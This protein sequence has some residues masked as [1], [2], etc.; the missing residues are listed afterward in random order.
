VSAT[1]KERK[2]EYLRLR[3]VADEALR[4]D[5]AGL[6]KASADAVDARDT[7]EREYI[8]YL[9]DLLHDCHRSTL[10]FS[11]RGIRSAPYG[12]GGLQALAHYSSKPGDDSPP[13]LLGEFDYV[14]TVSGGGYLGGWLSAWRYW[15]ENGIR[16]VINTLGATPLDKLDP[17]PPALRHLRSYTAYLTPRTGFLSADTWTLIATYMRNI[18]LNWLVLMPIFGAV[19]MVPMVARAGA[20]LR[21]DFMPFAS[22]QATLALFL[23]G[24]FICIVIPTAY[25]ARVL[26]SF[27]AHPGTQP[28]YFAGVLIPLSL[29]AVLLS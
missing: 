26:P 7:A 20:S 9:V 10:R 11:G 27:G 22:D 25:V 12:L 18:F 8:K 15:S 21:A 17:E 28:Q 24:G 16:G 5:P 23:V 14:S 19:V 2:G 4:D 3:A 6:S 1:C 29:G 13:T